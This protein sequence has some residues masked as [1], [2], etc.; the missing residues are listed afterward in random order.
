MRLPTFAIIFKQFIRVGGALVY[1]SM[2]NNIR[3]AVIGAGKQG[4]KI[5]EYLHK[6]KVLEAVCDSNINLKEKIVKDYGVKYY[7]SHKDLLSEFSTNGQSLDLCVIATPA[8]T[9][10]NIAIDILEEKIHLFIE[11]PLTCLFDHTVKIV[12]K[13]EQQKVLLACGYSERF[14]PVIV[15]L[16]EIVESK[17]LGE[18][19]NLRFIRAS[20]NADDAYSQ[21]INRIT[22]VGVVFDISVHDIDLALYLFHDSPTFVWAQT[23]AS[24]KN[25]APGCIRFAN[26][27]SSEYEDHAEILLGFGQRSARITSSWRLGRKE[28]KFEATFSNGIIVGTLLPGESQ[29]ICSD[30]SKFAYATHQALNDELDNLISLIS[31]EGV[32]KL[33]CDGNEAKIIQQIADAIFRSAREQQAI[34]IT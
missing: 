9:H 17:I 22:D 33:I 5:I 13:A 26:N 10:Y 6:L 1:H 2:M 28:R 16:K 18:L 11:K 21:K 8:S 25:I 7:C 4:I 20:L 34:R 23:S 12:R 31:E 30:K 24:H 14:H 19:V 15:K 29:L 27:S 32:G 3:V